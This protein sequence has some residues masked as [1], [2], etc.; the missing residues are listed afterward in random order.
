MAKTVLTVLL[1]I[2]GFLAGA[3]NSGGSTHN[4]LPP[5][6]KMVLESRGVARQGGEQE[7]GGNCDNNCHITGKW[8][9]YGTWLCRTAPDPSFG[10][11]KDTTCDC[12]TTCSQG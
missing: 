11:I 10:C 2:S 4:A 5:G 12:Y 9:P 3:W 7:R 8:C 6:Y 1:V